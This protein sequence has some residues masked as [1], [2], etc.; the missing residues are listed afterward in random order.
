MEL[1]QLN[2][3]ITVAKLCNFTKAA[4]QLGYSQ[5]SITSQIQILEKELETN[6]FERLGKSVSLTPAGEKFLVY[7]QQ[8]DQLCHEAKQA[9]AS[10]NV[11]RGTLTI[12][13]AES[14]CVM[15]LPALFKEFHACYPEVEIILKMGYCF[16][17]FP[18]LKDNKIDAAFLLDRKSQYEDFLTVIELP[19]P[20]AILA[21]PNHPLIKKTEIFPEDLAGYPLVLTEKSCSYRTMFEKILDEAGVIT[22]AVM[23]TDSIQAIKQMTISGLGITMLPRIAVVEELKNGDLQE[24]NWQ[25]PG[26]QM[27]T[28]CIYHKDKWISPALKAFLNMSRKLM[29]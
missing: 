23:E 22:N 28:K 24:L 17:F 15:R 16:D 3:F 6:L 18:M 12:G 1:R 9:V 4:A 7:A 10:D 19:E 25:G 20:M 8:I 21:N 11:V 27:I 29:A 14:L 26:L 13:S 2:T 5:S